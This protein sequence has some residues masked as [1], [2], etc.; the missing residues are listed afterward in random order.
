MLTLYIWLHVWFFFT[1]PIGRSTSWDQQFNSHPGWVWV[2][3]VSP[4]SREKFSEGFSRPPMSGNIC[5]GICCTPCLK[6]NWQWATCYNKWTSDRRLSFL[7]S[8]HRYHYLWADSKLR[9]ATELSRDVMPAKNCTNGTNIVIISTVTT[10]NDY[11]QDHREHHCERSHTFAVS[12]LLMWWYS[13]SWHTPPQSQSLFI[14]VF[15]DVICNCDEQNSPLLTHTTCMIPEV[16]AIGT[17]SIPSCPRLCRYT[18][19]QWPIETTFTFTI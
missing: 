2:P 8:V 14:V 12:T 1:E 16:A 6:N 11:G 13:Q 3:N 18:P 19:L 9:T 17:V 10:S 4:R 15:H 5:P 7:N